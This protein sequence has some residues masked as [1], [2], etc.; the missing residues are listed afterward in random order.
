MRQPPGVAIVGCGLIGQKRAQALHG[1][2]L[3]WCVDVDISSADR[4]ARVSESAATSTD[5]ALALS[6][7][8]VEIVIVATPNNSLAPV[9]QAAVIAGKHVLVEKPAA[10][11][12][13]DLEALIAATREVGVCVRVGFNHRYHPSFQKARS[14]VSEG[15]LGP[16]MFARA[17]YGH[18]GRIG[19]EQE[20]RADPRISGGGELIDQGVHVIDLARWF[21]GDFVEINGHAQTCFWQMPVDDNAF[22]ILRTASR[23]TAF[24]HV[25]CSE[26]KNLFSFELYGRYGK[27]QIDGLGGSYGT[28]KL[29]FYKM[30]PEMGPPETT[31]WE[32]PQKDRSWEIEFGEFLEDI[33]IGREPSANLHDA[34]AAM[35]VVNTI[36]TESGYDYNT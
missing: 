20:W 15:V 10:R 24:L 32:Y 25:S 12:I 2:T 34:L 26:W 7:P 36:Y 11:S 5:L 22:M 18:G 19:Y 30:L 9:A 16:L 23:Q 8:A 35:Q 17:R 28:E 4:L 27:L 31:S 6:D 33:R 14:L 21:L 3:R 1:A 13:K 29:T